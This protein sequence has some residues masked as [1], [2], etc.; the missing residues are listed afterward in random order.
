[1]ILNQLRIDKAKHGSVR[2]RKV[3]VNDGA[4]WQGA[5][6]LLALEYIFLLHNTAHNV[7]SIREEGEP[8]I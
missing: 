8:I 6:A 3:K 5:M 7:I 1:M 2:C 4:G